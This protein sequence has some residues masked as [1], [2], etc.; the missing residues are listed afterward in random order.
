MPNGRRGP[1]VA[2]DAGRRRLRTPS[3][4]I[5][6]GGTTEKPIADASS[7][8]A[9]LRN[10]NAARGGRCTCVRAAALAAACVAACVGP[11]TAGQE[12]GAEPDRATPKAEVEAQPEPTVGRAFLTAFSWLRDWD[13]PQPGGW[14]A[15]PAGVH[16]VMVSLRLDGELLARS[17]VMQEALARAAAEEGRDEPE[18]ALLAAS[19]KAI[20]AGRHRLLRDAPDGLSDDV[21]LRAALRRLTFDV[22]FAGPLVPVD[23]RSFEEFD[24]LVRAG[25]EGVAARVGDE[26][27]ASFPAEHLIAGWTPSEAVR[28]VAG[29]LRLPAD[30]PADLR[31]EQGARF[32][33]FNVRH[34]A[35]TP[36]F[37]FPI[38][39]HRGGRVVRQD[40]VTRA[41]LLAGAEAMAT[42]LMTREPTDRP[43]GAVGVGPPER[44]MGLFGPYFAP[45]D[46]YQPAFAEPRGQALAAY[47]L[48]RLQRLR[49]A[50]RSLQQDATDAAWRVLRD[51]ATVE[52]G[53]TAPSDEAGAEE[54]WLLA[55]SEVAART[56]PAGVDRKPLDAEARRVVAALVERLGEPAGFDPAA[57]NADALAALAVARAAPLVLPEPA[58]AIETAG[59]RVRLIFGR[60]EPQRLPAFMPWLAW[61]ELELNPPISSRIGS[62]TA[63][64]DETGDDETD[65]DVRFADLPAAAALDQMR[66]LVESFQVGPLDAG[67]EEPD[68]VGGV[69]FTQGA[70]VLPTWQSLRVASVLATML[71][72]PRLTPRETF[73]DRTAVVSAAMRF[74]LNLTSSAYEAHMY[75][76]ARRGIGGVRLAPWDHTMTTESTAMGL[77]TM[78]EAVRATDARLPGQLPTDR[79]PR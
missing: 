3:S 23:A 20:A 75:P 49:G 12:R 17:T 2:C 40:D 33:R 28:A 11:A 63:G 4:G 41:A 76:V 18:P 38:E 69:V 77:L 15:Q 65:D 53:E 59:R 45:Q 39:L 31:A 36:A 43:D 57:M 68:L 70:A 50:D 22:Q 34:L 60:V 27:V 10:R 25:L 9:A 73:H 54:A 32:Y 55:W 21:L 72:D 19:R 51:L 1:A 52:E 14:A 13:T 62:D 47:A 44:A 8:A 29:R 66:E 58:E 71:G 48:G 30:E 24:A 56:P 6:P 46:R 78:I 5:A 37:R 79:R 74:A 7:D 26:L 16:G 61:A 67:D 64:D 35:Q 42:H